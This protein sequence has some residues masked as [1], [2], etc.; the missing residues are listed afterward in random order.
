[1]P[2][3]NG[4]L[5]VGLLLLAPIINLSEVG[6]FLNPVR[7]IQIPPWQ[8]SGSREEQFHVSS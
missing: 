1:M 4:I 6:A 7:S 8:R 2:A 3:C 5:V